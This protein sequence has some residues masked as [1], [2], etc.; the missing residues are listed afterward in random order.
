M[1]Y[2]WKFLDILKVFNDATLIFYGV[3]Y[4]TAHLFLLESLNIVGTLDEHVESNDPN[5]FILFE[6]I[7][8]M[9]VK[10]LNY[11]R[12]IPLLYLIAA[13]FDPKFKL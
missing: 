9:K 11:F 8:G 7:T 3:Y 13:I 1:G 5:D 12:E 4:H 10:W 6:A 2:L